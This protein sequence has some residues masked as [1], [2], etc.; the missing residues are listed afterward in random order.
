MKGSHTATKRDNHNTYENTKTKDSMTTS[1]KTIYINYHRNKGY[2][3]FDNTLSLPSIESHRV[4]YEMI[5]IIISITISDETFIP[6]PIICRQTNKALL[7]IVLSNQ[8]M[9]S[10]QSLE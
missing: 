4:D 8:E 10:W 7:P 1:A 9:A 6:P 5:M 3:H 2:V